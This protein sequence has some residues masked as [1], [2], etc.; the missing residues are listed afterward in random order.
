MS[1]RFQKRVKLF[2]GITLNVSKTGVSVTVGAPG[3]SLNLNK[4]NV[5]ANLGLPG[6]GL[7]TRTNL[8][9]KKN[10]SS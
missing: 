2:P 1:V 8:T 7:S 3:A 6:T 4:N 9:K 5:I 10:K